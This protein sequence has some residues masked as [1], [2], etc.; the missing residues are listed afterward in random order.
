MTFYYY[1]K[2]N[3]QPKQPY[4][5]EPTLTSQTFSLPNPGYKK[6]LHG[7]KRLGKKAFVAEIFNFYSTQSRQTLNAGDVHQFIIFLSFWNRAH[8]DTVTLFLLCLVLCFPFVSTHLFT[9]KEVHTIQLHYYHYCMVTLIKLLIHQSFRKNK[10][11]DIQPLFFLG[12]G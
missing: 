10:S 2:L 5:I 3:C 12:R 7:L 8:M 9:C 4:L 6:T 11:F 1:L